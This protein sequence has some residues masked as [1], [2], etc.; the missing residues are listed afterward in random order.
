MFTSHAEL[1]EKGETTAEHT[2]HQREEAERLEADRAN[3]DPRT[4]GL[5]QGSFKERVPLGRPIIDVEDNVTRCP[6]CSWELEDDECLHCGYLNDESATGTGTETDENSEMTDYFDE[7]DDIDEEP[8]WHETYEGIPF[9]QLPFGLHQFHNQSH[10]FHLHHHLAWQF[11]PSGSSPMP[12]DSDE[13]E[14]SDDEDDMESFLDDEQ[15]DDTNTDHSTIVG[16]RSP[17]TETEL[18]TGSDVL[19]HDMGD[20][21]DDPD[22]EES[23]GDGVFISHSASDHQR[24]TQDTSTARAG[25]SERHSG[26]HR[27]RRGNGGNGS[28]WQPR[29][30]HQSRHSPSVESAG[31]STQNAISL[32]DDSEDDAPIPPTRRSRNQRNREVQVSGPFY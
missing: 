27:G 28:R 4:G 3:L 24:P 8:S 1:L 16:D 17:I 25:G 30:L 13:D 26:S 14:E 31:S 21:S 32:D 29:P 12:D 23:V 11:P 2:K 15:E 5:F 19:S 6:I 20:L 7:V 10:Q 22:E 9:E 18:E